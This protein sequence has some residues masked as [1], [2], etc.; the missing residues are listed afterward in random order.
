MSLP[1][2]AVSN[3]LIAQDWVATFTAPLPLAQALLVALRSAEIPAYAI[4]EVDESAFRALSTRSPLDHTIYVDRQ[5]RTQAKGIMTSE[6]HALEAENDTS[7]EIDQEFAAIVEQLKGVDTD[8]LD[9]DV[10]HFTPPSPPLHISPDP[11]TRAAWIGLI[12]GPLLLLA[13]VWG[14]LTLGGLAPLIGVA[15][16]V[17]GFIALVVRMPHRLPID[18]GPDDGAVL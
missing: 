16:F 17:S 6:L 3:G 5:R 18:E 14:L 2:G 8:E 7:P 1:V 4:A 10:E 13:N 12:G 15:A 9:I 11:V